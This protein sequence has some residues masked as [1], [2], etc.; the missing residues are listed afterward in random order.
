MAIVTK[1]IGTNSRDYSTEVLWEADLDNVLV[2]LTGDT[3]VGEGYNDSVF[4]ESIVINGGGTVG[5][6]EVI[7]SVA[8]GQRHNGIA[9]SGT[10]NVRTAD[11]GAAAIYDLRPLATLKLTLAWWEISANDKNTAY[12]IRTDQATAGRVPIIRNVLIHNAA[13]QNAATKAIRGDDRDF[14]MM[15][16]ILYRW[17][18]VADNRDCTGIAYDGDTSGSGLFNNTVH[19]IVA[20]GSGAATGIFINTNGSSALVKNNMATSTASGS[21]TVK[22]FSF[23][24]TTVDDATNLST[25]ATADDG[26]GSG[27]LINKTA[28]NQYVSTTVGSEDLH[29][30]AGADAIDAGTDLGTSPSNVQFDIDNYDRDTGGGAWDIG[31]DEFVGAAFDAALI[32]GLLAQAPPVRRPPEI[33]GY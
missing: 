32:A 25:D 9:G 31:A 11:L 22:D 10:R 2:Y 21:G 26:G 18:T 33:V 23:P 8:A 27:N 24:G 13:S 28:S 5:L 7:L 3:A 20:H 29:L 19:D 6:A 4:D 16:S 14:L 15:N 30:K 1:S 12:A 17:R